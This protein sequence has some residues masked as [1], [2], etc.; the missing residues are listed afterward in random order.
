MGK[1]AHAP[2]EGAKKLAAFIDK[3]GLSRKRTA[4]AVDSTHPALLAWLRGICKPDAY[5]RALIER[6]TAGAVPAS[7]WLSE[8]ERTYLRKIRAFKGAA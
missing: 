3:S 8:P 4:E 5:R 6:W 1:V 2:S 7:A